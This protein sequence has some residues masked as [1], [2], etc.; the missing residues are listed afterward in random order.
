MFEFDFDSME[1]A[2]LGDEYLSVE[3]YN[4][5]GETLRTLRAP[6]IETVGGVKRCVQD[7][8]TCPQNVQKLLLGTRVLGDDDT[9]ALLPQPLHMTLVVLPYSAGMSSRL[10]GAA[11]AGDG[12]GVAEALRRS[13]DPDHTDAEGKSALHYASERGDLPSLLELREAGADAEREARSGATPLLLA[14]QQGRAVIVQFLCS[15]GVDANRATATGATPLILASR[16][17]HA[18]VVRCLCAAG[19]DKDK[20]M[21]TGTTPL[22][23][24]QK[25]GHHSVV[26][27]LLHEGARKET[28]EVHRR[29]RNVALGCPAAASSEKS[30]ER[31][32][33]RAVDGCPSTRWTSEYADNQWLSVDLG[34]YHNLARVDV[35]WEAAH[36]KTYL[37]QGSVTGTTWRTLAVEV[38][39]EGWVST[40]LPA[41]SV[42]RWVRVHGQK[43]ATGFGFS[44]WELCVFAA[45][46]LAAWPPCNGGMILRQ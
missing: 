19:A 8:L 26:Q 39:R 4:V 27:L 33:S 46:P 2:R 40:L 29:E 18:E 21:R 30:A 6:S 36:A 31:A 37:L 45:D 32:A 24:A 16:E 17:G 15:A 41:G 5:A 20:P 42:A 3:V 44:I 14:A 10:L 22:L 28:M 7:A 12:A 35:R 11:Q 13:A 43:R 34:S 9:L 23:I 25:R 38:G 1:R